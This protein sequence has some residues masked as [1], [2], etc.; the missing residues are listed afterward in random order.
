VGDGLLGAGVLDGEGGADVGGVALG[1]AVGSEGGLGGVD[2][3]SG[4]VELLELAALA[5]EQDQAGLVVVEAGDVGDERLLG[6][7]GAAV[8][9]GDADG[10]RQLLG[11]AGFLLRVSFVFFLA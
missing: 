2:L 11:N 4:G 5:G 8:V 7:V 3:V 6:V 10:A 9:D 1:L